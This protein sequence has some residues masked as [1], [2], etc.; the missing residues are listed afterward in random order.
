MPLIYNSKKIIPAPLMS[1]SRE[2]ERRANSQKK[3]DVFT[4]NLIGT[5]HAYK[6]SPNDVGDF[7]SLSGYPSDTNTSLDHR[8]AAIQTKIGAL[9]ELFNEE[10]KWLESEPWDGSPPIKFLARVKSMNFQEGPWVE[11]C[12]YN[13]TLECECIYFGNTEICAF[14]G[15]DDLVDENWD[16]EPL[17]ESTRNYRITHTLSAQFMD[18]RNTDGTLNQKGH[19]R[20]R[21]AV[22][23]K[24]GL[25]GDRVTQTGV[26][27]LSGVTGYNHNRIINENIAEGSYRVVE[28]WISAATKDVNNP[29]SIEDYTISLTDNLGI[30]TAKIDGQITGLHER[31]ADFAITTSRLDNANAK[32]ALVLPTLFT[33][34]QAAT[35]RILNPYEVGRQK[36]TN[37][38][39]GTINYSY[40]YNTRSN[41]GI[42][43]ARQVD[44]NISDQL[45]RDIFAEIT[46][47]NRV[48]GPILQD[49]GTV[50]SRKRTISVDVLMNPVDYASILPPTGVDVSS[51]IAYYTPAG[52]S[53]V[54][55]AEDNVNY[56][57]GQGRYQRTV[58]YVFQ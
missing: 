48:L 17:D 49:I 31:D 30:L 38:A 29:P 10:N 41:F 18:S 54:F 32:W 51:I 52:Y 13:I 12:R 6:G 8:Q 37:Y 26:L 23:A 33:R 4:V 45:P 44:V 24:L 53:Q 5:I 46:V 25:V 11:I 20:A 58:S 3:K 2:T 50:T 9:M 55:L 1:I 16:I 47:I 34:C 28:T 7:H 27:N 57:L 14:D 19:I 35:E 36:T 40:E 56:G 22:I 21:E 15:V 42:A 39:Q 43:G